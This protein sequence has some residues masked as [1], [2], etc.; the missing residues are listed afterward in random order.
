MTISVGDKLPDVTLVNATS[1][2]DT[3]SSPR[4][5]A[6]GRNSVPTPVSGGSRTGSP[7]SASV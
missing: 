7:T 6:A 1:P 5:A 3:R 2:G 4:S